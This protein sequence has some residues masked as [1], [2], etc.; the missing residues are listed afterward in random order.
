[1]SGN[2][3]FTDEMTTCIKRASTTLKRRLTFLDSSDDDWEALESDDG[4]S[5]PMEGDHTLQGRI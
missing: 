3:T 2:L 4:L 1:M 5:F